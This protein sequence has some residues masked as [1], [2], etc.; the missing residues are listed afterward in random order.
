MI[1]L[2]SMIPTH[3]EIIST[4]LFSHPCASHVRD[5]S[6]LVYYHGLFLAS[7]APNK[8]AIEGERT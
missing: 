2:A 3:F 8:T 1:M 5:L 4:G 7:W 6:R